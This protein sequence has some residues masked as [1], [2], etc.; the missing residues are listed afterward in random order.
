MHQGQNFINQTGFLYSGPNFSVNL[1]LRFSLIQFTKRANASTGKSFSNQL[2][3]R[4]II[5][6]FDGSINKVSTIQF[7]TKNSSAM[8][9]TG[10][11]TLL[12]HLT[13]LKV[14]AFLSPWL[15]FIGSMKYADIAQEIALKVTPLVLIHCFKPKYY[16]CPLFVAVTSEHLWGS[17]KTLFECTE[18][19]FILLPNPHLFWW[20]RGDWTAGVRGFKLWK[21]YC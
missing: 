3:L 20:S 19:L 8:F 1:P 18:D 5:V 11:A 9:H 21:L 7:I 16:L 2:D 4:H 10:V 14:E 15:H 12:E 6:R 17:Q 13:L